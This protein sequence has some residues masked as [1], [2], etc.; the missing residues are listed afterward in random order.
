MIYGFTIL[1][2]PILTG[3]NSDE[4]K[5]KKNIKKTNLTYLFTS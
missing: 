1:E 4:R 5:K 2:L 3:S